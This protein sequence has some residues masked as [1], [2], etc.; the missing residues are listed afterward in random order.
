MFGTAFQLT[1]NSP[2]LGK[3]DPNADLGGIALKDIN[4]EPRVKR[5]GMGADIGAD[6]YYP[7]P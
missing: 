5:P 7:L 3:A 1:A 4:G 6:Q 2:L